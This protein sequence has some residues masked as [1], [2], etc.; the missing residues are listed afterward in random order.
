MKKFI[1]LLFFIM[2]I[3][4]LW[5]QQL[6]LLDTEGNI[7]NDTVTYTGNASNSYSEHLWV[8][9]SASTS[10]DVKVK[11]DIIELAKG[12]GY[13]FCW[14]QCLGTPRSGTVSGPLTIPA[15]DTSK[16]FVVDYDPQGYPGYSLF[17][18]AFFADGSTDTSVVYV[19]FDIKSASPVQEISSGIKT[20]PNPA[21]DFIIIKNNNVNWLW[22]AELSNL[23]GQILIRQNSLSGTMILDIEQLPSGMYILTIKDKNK[24]L[25]TRKIIVNH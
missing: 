3:T 15:G 21:S 9:N 14:D 22:T 12:V 24:I 11:F 7:L 19:A 13:A 18:F 6:K 8:Y 10:M 17:R 25:S 5:P 4:T 16:V 2:T 20:F 1:I 23:S